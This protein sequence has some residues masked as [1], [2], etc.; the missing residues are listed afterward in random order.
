MKRP[1]KQLFW[2]GGLIISLLFMAG[3]SASGQEQP[4]SFNRKIVNWGFKVG[5]NA[6]A[7]MRLQGMQGE[8][9]LANVSYRNKSGCDITGFFRVN[10][11]RF[12]IQPEIGWSTL[13]KDLLFAFPSEPE[14]IFELSLHTQ[15]AN[16]NGLIGYNITKTGPFVFNII[17]GS[18]LRYK[19]DTRYSAAYPQNEH[20]DTNPVYNAY[21]VVG[22]SM[23]ISNVHFD[24][25]YAISMLDVDMYFN[26]IADKPEW[27]N[28]VL[29]HKTEN[30]LSFSCGVM[31]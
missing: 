12:F 31:F 9:E 15:T 7:V 19:F 10:L 17:A 5:L 21:G 18:S 20:R 14:Q 23:N 28:N 8:E 13:N 1:C 22:F 6:N 4:Y 24:I 30:I 29:F 3:A 26:D 11:N 25:R 2:K 16:A 27:M